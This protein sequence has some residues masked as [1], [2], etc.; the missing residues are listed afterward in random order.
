MA[1]FN[2]AHSSGGDDSRASSISHARFS[3]NWIVSPRLDL[4][5][6]IGA[7]LLGYGMFFLHA[8]LAMDMVA[9]WFIWYMFLD[10]PHFFATYSRTYFDKEEMRNRRRLLLGS[11]WLLIAG[12]VIFAACLGLFAADVSW[13]KTP[14]FMLVTFVSVWAYWHVLRQHFGIMSLYKRK[15]N[16]GAVIDQKLDRWVL[17]IGLVAPFLAFIVKNQEARVELGYLFG[18]D[19]GAYTGAAGDIDAMI[20]QATVIAA[21]LAIVTFVARQVQRWATGE[22]VN[23][24]KILFLCAVIPLH[25]V[26]CYHPD[27]STLALLG[28]SACVTIFHDVQYHAIV[29]WYQRNRMEKAGG[30]IDPAEPSHQSSRSL[31]ALRRIFLPRAAREATEKYGL[32]SK[33]GTSLPI[34]IIC[35]VGMGLTFGLMGCLLDVNPGCLPVIGSRDVMVAGSELSMNELFYGVFL[36]VLMHH[37]FVDQFI[38]RPSKDRNVTESLKLQ[39]Q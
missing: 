23:A 22:T 7:A 24:A 38:W 20:V 11:L 30:L 17:Y 4:I 16:D 37:Y 5:C 26:V 13:Y 15:N 19:I 8:G 25:L 6:F 3:L 2:S 32:A 29:W 33:I 10:S 35:A 18:R 12:P 21:A 27:S 28:F 1:Q 14:Y 31:A 39:K 36:G 9:V 34:Y